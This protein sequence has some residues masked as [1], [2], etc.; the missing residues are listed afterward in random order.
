MAHTEDRMPHLQCIR[1]SD[2][3]TFKTEGAGGGAVLVG[4]VCG[5]LALA[6]VGQAA[7]SDI[8]GLPKD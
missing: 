5:A 4:V 3:T 8:L 6:I 1:V 2:F 7:S